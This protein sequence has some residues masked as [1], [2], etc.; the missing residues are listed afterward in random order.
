MIP[1]AVSFLAALVSGTF[2]LRLFAQWR[3]RRRPHAL[4]WAVS[5]ELF[6][7]ASLAAALG[8]ATQWSPLVFSVYWFA[9]GLIVVPFLAAGQL[10]LMDPGRMVIWW[11]LAGLFALWA[12]AALAMSDFNAA[13]LAA[14]DTATSIPRGEDV[15]GSGQLAFGLLKF[16]N[17]TAAVVVVGTVWSAVKS[18]RW[19]I[20]LIALG[21]TIAGASFV[22]I[23]E[24]KPIGFSTSLAV[25]VGAMYAGFLA[26]GKPPKARSTKSTPPTSA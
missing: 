15:F 5:L 14:A 6:S 19:M 20:L 21:V 16:A 8:M 1:A 11:T 17:Y 7:L 24:G 23:R 18:R 12:L 3:E 26:A 13:A 2:A 4:A 22:F 10:M 25:G 9:G